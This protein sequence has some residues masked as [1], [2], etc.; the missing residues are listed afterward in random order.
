[1]RHVLSTSVLGASS[2]RRAEGDSLR[3]RAYREI[4]ELIISAELPPAALI[5][6]ARLVSDLK[7]GYTPVR[8]ALQRLALDNLVVILPRRGTIVA[9][10]NASDL[11]KIYEIRVELVP[12]AAR[13]AAEH[14]TPAQI[15]GMDKLLARS[16][17]IIAKG[18]HYQLIQLDRDF[19]RLL[20]EATH[21]EFLIETLDGLYSHALRLW[22]MH[23]H[24]IRSL[25]QEIR[26]HLRVLAAIKVRD[27]RRA[28]AIMRDTVV[29]FHREQMTLTR[30]LPHS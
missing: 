16:M 17:K 30:S 22:Y 7:L 5:D 3:H 29:G 10:L 1:M 18:D 24:R 9:D 13:L 26:D 4:K 21:N 23:L 20:A 11:E 27:G 15:V 12:H 6:E 8:Q 28:A 25:R 19:Q 2:R 14:A